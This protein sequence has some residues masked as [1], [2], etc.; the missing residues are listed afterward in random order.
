VLSSRQPTGRM[1][2]RSSFDKYDARVTPAP[3]D[4]TASFRSHRNY[5]EAF[6]ILAGFPYMPGR[7]R[8]VLAQIAANV[9]AAFPKTGGNRQYDK[10]E[11]AACL[12]RAWGTELILATGMRFDSE[13]GFMRIANSWG[14]VQAYYVGYS[15][16]QALIIANGHP[17]PPSHPKTQDQAI[18]LWTHRQNG[19]APFS[20][21]AIQ[22]SVLNKDPQ[23]YAHGPGRD[24]D[25]AVHSWSACTTSN[26]WDIAALALRTTREDVVNAAMHEARQRK[27]REKRKDW[28]AAEQAR[29][30]RGKS[31]R[32]TPTFKTAQLTADEKAACEK[33][34]RPYGLLDYLFRLRIKANYED[35]EMFTDGPE[36]ETSSVL[37]AMSMVRI[38]TAIMMAHEMRIAQ[39]LG[40]DAI[41]KLAR[42]WV[43]K[44]APSHTIGIALRLPIL[45]QVL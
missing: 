41:L 17:R 30:A 32:P 42:S 28:S 38:A 26:S 35:A 44:N 22:G 11:M 29:L 18:A 1:R 24:I 12:N 31:A 37:V 34:V 8:E 20:F 33:A 14:C 21:A 4:L 43:T 6:T 3:V 10:T 27:V 40:R 25:V 45:E 23:A 7:G 2:S 39:L 36:D 16:T 5:L 13:D 15:A 9:I 19:V